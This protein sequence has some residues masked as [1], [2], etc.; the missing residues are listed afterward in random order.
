MKWKGFF[1]IF[2]LAG[3]GPEFPALKNPP[4]QFTEGIQNDTFPEGLPLY[5][6]FRDERSAREIAFENQHRCFMGV[7]PEKSTTIQDLYP[8]LE[9]KIFDTALFW[10]V[11]T[12]PSALTGN[13][14]GLLLYGKIKHF[15]MERV[16]RTYHYRISCEYELLR[17]E[18][19]K[20]LASGK[21]E[22]NGKKEHDIPLTGCL[23]SDPILLYMFEHFYGR[24]TFKHMGY[25]L[26]NALAR[27]LLK[28]HRGEN[29]FCEIEKTSFVFEKE[30]KSL[31]RYR[32]IRQLQNT[33]TFLA[34]TGLYLEAPLSYHI[35][36]LGVMG[37]TRDMETGTL[38]W[39]CAFL[40]ALAG[41]YGAYY[42]TRSS[43]SD[44]LPFIF[45]GAMVGGATGYAL[46]ENI[47]PGGD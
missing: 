11:D 20:P 25:E 24:E 17:L 8:F 12:L 39:T 36:P 19:F 46:G 22:L 3:C 2:L 1:F 15:V 45:V 21:I 30:E 40:G 27:E 29:E 14:K 5:L 4:P 43:T 42:F 31:V 38:A 28:I 13:E 41:G 34:L 10:K 33:A 32:V 7:V 16:E 23:Y 6:F 18:D 35:L 47:K 9:R 26:G 37:I 44:P